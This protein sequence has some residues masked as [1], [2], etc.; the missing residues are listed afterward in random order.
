MHTAPCLTP[1]PQRQGR[2]SAKPNRTAGAGPCQHSPCIKQWCPHAHSQRP[3][4]RSTSLSPSR[5]LLRLWLCTGLSEPSKLAICCWCRTR[6]ALLLAA[7]AAACCAASSDVRTV[8]SS[9][10]CVHRAGR[11]PA[12][13]ASAGRVATRAWMSDATQGQ[14]QCWFQP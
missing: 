9:K 7:A 6:R 10:V 8:C 12:H 5:A 13:K 4:T 11:Q 2:T 14:L 1:S 3:L